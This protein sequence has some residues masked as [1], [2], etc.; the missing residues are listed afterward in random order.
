MARSIKKGAYVEFKLLEKVK[1]TIK[2]DKKPIKTWSRRSTVI[3]EFVGHTFLVYN[4]QK[5]LP[6]YITE[7]MVG[8]LLGE[9]VPTRVF[10]KHG[11]VGTKA[12]AEAAAAAKP[13]K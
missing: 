3:P 9:F 2:Q 11:G 10:R 5:F 13:A 6:V 4:G 12:A 8:H 7:N 1:N